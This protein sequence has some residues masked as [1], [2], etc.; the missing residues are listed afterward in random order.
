MSLVKIGYELDLE[1]GSQWLTVTPSKNAKSSLLYVQELGDFISHQ[2]Y[3]TRREG[4]DSY[5][6]K[7]T[8]SGEGLLDYQGQT[9]PV[10]PGQIFFIDCRE[11]QYY[12]TSPDVGHWRVLWVHFTGVSASLYYDLFQA[13]NRR[14]PTLTMPP[15]N[16]LQE[17]LRE[18][19]AIYDTE[20]SVLADDLYAAALLTRMLTDVLRVTEEARHWTG[21]PE[22]VERA[23]DY[24]TEHY[25]E[26][27][28]LDDLAA[29]Y[30]VSKFHFQKQFKH[31]IGYTPN[32]FL[33]Q[34]R[35]NHAK[36]FLRQTDHPVSQIACDVGIQNVSHFINLFK[37]QEGTTP[38]VYRNSYS[39]HSAYT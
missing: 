38:M 14:S 28:T 2:K 25:N 34:L 22:S 15:D 12:R 17:Y 33:L 13:Q 27:I 35:L 6:I 39:G 16:H 29:R 20:S 5:L 18:L 26:K 23:R 3:Y 1:P 32:E 30:S 36:E 4:L 11:P 37:K 7:Y 9:Y 10:R 31:Y 8:L 21:I 19:I 24:L